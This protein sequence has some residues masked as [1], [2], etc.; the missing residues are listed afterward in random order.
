MKAYKAI[1]K[2]RGGAKFS[3]WLYR[4]AHNTFLDDLRKRKDQVPYGEAMSGEVSESKT[5]SSDLVQDLNQAFAFLRP[6]QVA[7]FD[8]YYKK[9]MSHSEVSESLDM[10]LGTVKTHIGRGLEILRKQLK[11][12]SDHERTTG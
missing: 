7:V 1:R 6:E 9:G 3:T 10:P 5:R 11:D 4:I 2:F 8:L 12:W